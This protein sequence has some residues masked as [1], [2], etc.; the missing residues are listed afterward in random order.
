MTLSEII[1]ALGVIACTIPLILAATGNAY[2]TRQAA[3]ADTRSAWLVRDVQRRIMDGWAQPGSKTGDLHAIPF[4]TSSPTTMELSFKQDGTWLPYGSDQAAYLAL[5]KAEPYMP[6]P[7]HAQVTPL[8]RITIRI[9][10]PA[11]A[12][13]NHRKQLSYRFLSS[14]NGMP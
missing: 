9:Q 4:P 8:A 13:S 14:R 11:K 12:P 6:E 1:I 5:I 10:Y 7:A 2:Q 3:E